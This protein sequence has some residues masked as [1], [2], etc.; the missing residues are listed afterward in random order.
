M[1]L[2]AKRPW[3]SLQLS[4][5]QHSVDTEQ[6]AL[7]LFAP[8][9]RWHRNWARFFRLD[10]AGVRRLLPNLQ[11]AGLL[12]DLGKANEEFQA[13]VQRGGGERRTQTLRHEHLSALVLSLPEVRQW[14]ASSPVVDV[15][16]VTA[17]VLSHHL[18]AS[19]GGQ[20]QWGAP[21]TGRATLPLLL[22]HP[23]VRGILERVREV[24]QVEVPAPT[25]R[26]GAWSLASPW[27]EAR[28]QGL[29]NAIQLARA[30]RGDQDLGRKRLLLAVKA[31]VIVADSVAS[32]L[33]RT[34]LPI[35]A[36][37]D[38]VA[39]APVL[40]PAD[41]AEKII[42]RRT[43]QIARKVGKPFVWHRF[44][45]LAAEQGPRALLL[46]GCGAGKTLA[47][48][49]WAHAQVA[50]HEVGRVI[51]LY[52]TRG[53]AT[54]GF[55]DYVG[56]APEADAALMHGTAGYE[57]EAM[58]DNPPESLEDKPQLRSEATERLYALGFWPRRFFSA[59]VD[60][61]LAFMEHDYGSLC[62]LPV[63]ADSVVVFDEV[64]SY[65]QRMFRNLLAFLEAFDVPV[66]CMTATLPPHRRRQLEDRGRLRTFPG[67]E[68]RAPLRD[69]EQQEER[70]RYLVRRVAGE[71]RARDEVVD[72]YRGGAR[73]LWVVNTV[74]RCQRVAD[75]LAAALGQ[76]V[77]V[78]H[79]RFC[80]R[81]RHAAHERTVAAFQQTE[82]PALA[83]TTQVCEMSLDL[84][85]DVLVTELAPVTALVQRFGRS[86]R[87]SSREADFRARVLWYE[88]ESVLPYTPDEMEAGR[89]FLGELEG[90][91]VSQRTLCEALERHA[92]EQPRERDGARFLDSGYYATPGSLR[93]EDEHTQPAVLDDELDEVLALLR[94]GERIDG[95][96]VPVPRRS[97]KEREDEPR[98]AGLPRYLGLAPAEQ[99][100]R[101]RGFVT[102]VAGTRED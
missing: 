10:D 79:S 22:E 48:W 76:D 47:A 23:E 13:L 46:A 95:F 91:A 85:A 30:I 68:H 88:A 99:Y 40:A 27:A 62:L 86:N 6:A 61:F 19:D 84:D 53:T 11:V 66:L 101:T 56:W 74:A 39:H 72:A 21:R 36:W 55:R 93:E 92:P 17:A 82:R 41:V 64:H 7:R 34:G 43:D 29:R 49:K 102:R 25:L 78:Y 4:L 75:E 44:Q 71:A 80:L 42:A 73:V 31:G 52:P 77:L 97:L 59:T 96:M 83:V 94:R 51:F 38:E 90:S 8:G 3:G 26:S 37:I 28:V 35:E 63:L 58:R 5:E 16:V 69:L 57:L 2:L 15:D 12:H 87:S 65:D 14:L 100:T 45:D 9:S 33:V 54:E 20:Y 32:G 24:A 70:E 89:R 1:S 50:A 18:K 67:A 60:R 98:A 81:D